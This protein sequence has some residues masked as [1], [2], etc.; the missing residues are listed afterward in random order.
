[1]LL[2]DVLLQRLRGFKLSIDSNDFVTIDGVVNGVV[3]VFAL[4]DVIDRCVVAE[5][6]RLLNFLLTVIIFP[7]LM[8]LLMALT[9]FLQFMMLSIN[10]LLL[11]SSGF[12]TF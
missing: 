1:M 7:L 4:A 12:K 8:L 9:Q 2:I 6:E 11:S 10:V 3:S 5:V